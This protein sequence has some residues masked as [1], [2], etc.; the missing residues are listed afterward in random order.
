MGSKLARDCRSDHRILFSEVRQA[1]SERAPEGRR[2]PCYLWHMAARGDIER[3]KAV[4]G[5]EADQIPQ[6]NG[7]CLPRLVAHA[8]VRNELRGPQRSFGNAYANQNGH[9][10][11]HLDHEPRCFA[12]CGGTR[13]LHGR[14]RTL[15]QAEGMQRDQPHMTSWRYRTSTGCLRL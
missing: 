6:K 13:W 7:S 15:M 1:K 3:G 11:D 9:R 14:K 10:V 4:L 12:T 5:F 2:R 8:L